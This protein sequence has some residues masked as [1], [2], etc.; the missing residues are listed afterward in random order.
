MIGAER[1]SQSTSSTRSIIVHRG[2]QVQFGK[3]K[4]KR[5][6][7]AKGFSAETNLK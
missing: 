3:G 1:V 4:G 5:T 7:L 6:P 2:Q